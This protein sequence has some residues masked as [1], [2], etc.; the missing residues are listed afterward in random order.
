[1]DIILNIQQLF[2]FFICPQI[3]TICILGDTRF[4]LQVKFTLI[5]ASIHVSQSIFRSVTFFFISKFDSHQKKVLVHV[6]F[7]TVTALCFSSAAPFEC[8]MMHEVS[9]QLT[10][11]LGISNQRYSLQLS[12]L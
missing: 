4:F 11:Q 2:T 12:Y 5:T 6:F 7:I 9:T 3:R 10:F 8:K 1:M